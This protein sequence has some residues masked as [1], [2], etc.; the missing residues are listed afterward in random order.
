MPLLHRR[1]AV[2]AFRR[3]ADARGDLGVA[4]RLVLHAAASAAGRPL[5]LAGRAREM[6]ARSRSD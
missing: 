6:P 3:A 1:G 2:R 5:D 4:A